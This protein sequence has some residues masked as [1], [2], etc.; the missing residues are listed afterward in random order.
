MSI[1]LIPLA[2]VVGSGVKTACGELSFISTTNL[3][4]NSKRTE[5]K[6]V[7]HP[8]PEFSQLKDPV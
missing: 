6:R 7:S 1:G 8:E 2:G 4:R 3:R 5:L